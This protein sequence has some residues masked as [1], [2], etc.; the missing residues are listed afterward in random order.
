MRRLVELIFVLTVLAIGVSFAGAIHPIGDSLAVFRFWLALL[1]VACAVVLLIGRRGA[2]L[3]LL[4]ACG[5]AALPIVVGKLSSKPR[6]DL[7]YT[8]YQK[9]L[10]YS[11]AEMADLSQDI[12]NSGADFVTLQE[13]FHKLE[14]AYNRLAQN[15][16]A[17]L[18]CQ[19]NGVGGNA[20]LSRWP[21]VEGTDTCIK[22]TGFAL[23]QVETPDG[24]VWVAS[25]HLPWPYPFQQ[26]EQ[27]DRIV[28]VLNA[29]NGPV[30]V[31]GDFNMV[32]W[33]HAVR[34]IEKAARSERAGP[35]VRTLTKTAGI[36]RLPI[37]HVLVPG[38][39][40]LMEIR[41]LLGSDHLGVVMHFNL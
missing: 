5:V 23:M 17:A 19:N 30:V 40:G 4:A 3:A 18:L 12:L 6:G 21:M 41:P 10:L 11:N 26:H 31:A 22:N 34:Q 7:A 38:G 35:V 29:L 25:L 32:P 28:P 37:D 1:L 33:S 27:V 24:P 13:V 2:L 14:P 16:A 8:L 20:V 36:L 39:Q 15:Y 9:N